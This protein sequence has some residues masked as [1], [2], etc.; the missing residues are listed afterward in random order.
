MEFEL[1]RRFGID[2]HEVPGLRLEMLYA[3]DAACAFVRVGLGRRRRRELAGWL[4]TE[5][6]REAASCEHS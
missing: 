5:A 6:L 4:L 3:S 1:C 2:V